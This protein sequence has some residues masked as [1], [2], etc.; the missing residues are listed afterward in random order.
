M[1]LH[2]LILIETLYASKS[3]LFLCIFFLST[4]LVTAISDNFLK[5]IHFLFL[6]LLSFH[7]RF[8]FLSSGFKSIIN[9]LPLNIKQF[10]SNIAAVLLKL[11]LFYLNYIDINML[12]NRIIF[13]INFIN[14]SFS[15]TTLTLQN[16]IVMQIPI[17]SM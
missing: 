17:G 6:T 9:V 13:L 15:F 14:T 4:N 5:D 3:P 12:T 2:P 10:F 7:I 11:F 8:H 16:D 1:S